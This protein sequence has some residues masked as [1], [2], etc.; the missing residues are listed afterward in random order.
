MRLVVAILRPAQVESVRR[1][2]AAVD[3]TRMTIGDAQGHHATEPQGHH[4]TKPQGHHG[5]KPQGH[6][7]TK[8][9]GHRGTKPHGHRRPV[10]EAVIE[11]A[12]NDDFVERAAGAIAG[13]LEAAGEDA[14]GRLFT[15]PIVEAVQIYRDV[16]GPEAV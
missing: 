15:L 14:K 6:H 7:G 2:L 1:A 11:I 13:V 3:V 8:P 5:T 12:C 16:R 4:G 10:Q 9:Q